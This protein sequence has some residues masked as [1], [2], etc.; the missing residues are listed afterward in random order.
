MAGKLINGAYVQLWESQGFKPVNPDVPVEEWKKIVEHYEAWKNTPV[1]PSAHDAVM[2]GIKNNEW[3]EIP[4]ASYELS[5]T[6][7]VEQDA[8]TGEKKLKS[9]VKMELRDDGFIEIVNGKFI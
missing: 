4:F 5:D 2:Y 3:K 6:I 7:V 1:P 8:S 9:V